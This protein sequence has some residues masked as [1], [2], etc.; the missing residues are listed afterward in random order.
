MSILGTTR[1][2]QIHTLVPT[3][4]CSPLGPRRPACPCWRDSQTGKFLMFLT[5]KIIIK[6]EDS[7]WHAMTFDRGA[8]IARC[9]CDSPCDLS[10]LDDLEVLGILLHPARK[11]IIKSLW[12]LSLGYF[13]LFPSLIYTW[14]SCFSLVCRFL[15]LCQLRTT[16]CQSQHLPLV[17]LHLFCF[18]VLSPFVFIWFCVSHFRINFT[19]IF[20]SSNVNCVITE[21]F[22]VEEKSL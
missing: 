5:W 3:A 6:S 8:C 22:V 11:Q 18:S 14:S 2:D 13:L 10:V 15:L 12:I 17:T 19:F 9:Q 7:S 16:R 20:A 1:S 4:P 21:K